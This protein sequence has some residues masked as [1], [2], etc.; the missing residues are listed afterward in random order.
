MV[1]ICQSIPS[2]CR[3]VNDEPLWLDAGGPDFITNEPKWIKKCR[4][5]RSRALELLEDR[6]RLWDAGLPPKMLEIEMT[7]SL[8]MQEVVSVVGGLH[9]RAWPQA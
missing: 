3:Y 9:A 5:I 4:Q 2:V 7:E 1:L 6:I 8:V